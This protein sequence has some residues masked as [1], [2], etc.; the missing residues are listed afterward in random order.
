M[1]EAV[2]L[3]RQTLRITLLR[4]SPER[5]R[6]RRS[7]AI[8]ALLAAVVVSAAAQAAYFGAHTVFV[9]L[10]VFAELV[11]FMLMMVLLTR[12]VVRLRLAQTMLA[13]VL[14]SVLHDVVL[15]AL[16]PLPLG[17]ASWPVAIALGAVAFY[18][19]TSV[20]MWGARQP[21]VVAGMYL[22]GYV[23]A[24]HA[25]DLAFRSLFD[26]AAMGEAMSSDDV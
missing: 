11:P 19:G 25:L 13:L 9:I 1:S 21:A 3:I 15:L 24:V 2:T 22:L 8:G 16:S 14:I 6:Y 26:V 23:A 5:I 18:G 12:K 10:R 7:L 17:P 20:L 4:G